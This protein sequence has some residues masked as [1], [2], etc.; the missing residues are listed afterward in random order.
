[1]VATLSTVAYVRHGT[2]SRRTDPVPRPTSPTSALTT[3]KST[4]GVT[5]QTGAQPAREPGV[6]TGPHQGLTREAG[7]GPAAAAK[8]GGRRPTW[9]S[10]EHYPGRPGALSLPLRTWCGDEIVTVLIAAA[11]G[12][13]QDALRNGMRG[14][15]V[16][17]VTGAFTRRGC[18]RRAHHAR[19]D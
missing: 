15:G 6:F 17:R 3:D 2:S 11:E 5:R 7:H 19:A 8:Y 12:E 9:P 1:M 13:L 10:S 18:D 4:T 16:S 14:W